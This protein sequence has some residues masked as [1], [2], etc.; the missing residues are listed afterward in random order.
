MLEEI[1]VL[2][3]DDL[4]W[5]ADSLC[6]EPRFASRANDWFSNRQK[7]IDF[8]KRTCM[9]CLVLRDCLSYAVATATQDGVWGATTA[10]ERGELAAAGLTAESVLDY[11]GMAFVGLDAEREARIDARMDAYLAE[12]FG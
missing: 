6:A 11:G 3:G 4:S 1:E 2:A 5:Q 12:K 8:A 7:D 9:A 10:R